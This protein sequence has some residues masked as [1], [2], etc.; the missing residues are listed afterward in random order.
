[1]FMGKKCKYVCSKGS[2]AYKYEIKYIY[3]IVNKTP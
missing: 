3:L 2:P 1:M